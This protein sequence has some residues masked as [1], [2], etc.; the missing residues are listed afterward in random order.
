MN[1]LDRG[2]EY[3]A[4][5]KLVD[6][7][8]YESPMS[9]PIGPIILPITSKEIVVEESNVVGVIVGVLLGSLC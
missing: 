8:G 3:F 9:A 6:K 1:E 4:A 2:V 7:D 5:A